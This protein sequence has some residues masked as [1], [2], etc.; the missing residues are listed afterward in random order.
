MFNRF[1][2]SILDSCK[3]YTGFASTVFC[4]N[5]RLTFGIWLG[6]ITFMFSLIEVKK[7]IELAGTNSL[8]PLEAAL[9]TISLG[10]SEW[11]ELTS[12]LY[13]GTSFCL[14]QPAQIHVSVINKGRVWCWRRKS[15]IYFSFLW[16]IKKKASA[17]SG[18]QVCLHF[19]STSLPK[20]NFKQCLFYWT[21]IFWK[22]LS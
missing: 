19:D 17:L 6:Y 8:G 22:W 21:K 4:L 1:I 10:C 18:K 12:F 13:I 20:R 3:C 2:E 16:E 15:W 14:K 9:T 11:Q 7:V 5:E